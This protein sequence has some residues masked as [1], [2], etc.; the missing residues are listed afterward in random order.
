MAAPDD[1]L[2]GV[3]PGLKFTFVPIKFP[4]VYT[5]PAASFTTQFAILDSF[6]VTGP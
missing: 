6:T 2:I 5:F 3:F 1:R 4:V